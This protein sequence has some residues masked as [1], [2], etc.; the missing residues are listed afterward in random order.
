MESS[1]ID[2]TER[3]RRTGRP[4]EEQVASMYRALGFRA[5]RGMHLAG[6]QVDVYAERELAG[7]GGTLRVAI[8]VK[9]YPGKAVDVDEV[10]A[11][12]I[13][14]RLIIGAGESDRCRL[15]TTGTITKASYEAV[16]PIAGADIITMAELERELLVPIPTLSMWLANYRERAATSHFIDLQA[17]LQDFDADEEVEAMGRPHVSDLLAVALKN[18]QCGLVVLGD[19]GAGKS[20]SMERI[21]ALAIEA[22]LQDP[23]APVP[24]LLRLGK[25]SDPRAVAQFAL[26]GVADEF[27]NEPPNDLFWERLQAGRFLVL[28]DGFDEISLRVDAARR[29]DLLQQLS[30]LLFTDSPAIISTRP[31]YFADYAEYRAAFARLN[32]GGRPGKAGTPTMADQ[33]THRLTQYLVDAVGPANPTRARRASIIT[34]AVEP[35]DEAG[36]VEYLR[37]R[38]QELITAGTTAT[39][40]REFLG[41]IY[42][43]SELITRPIILKMAVETAIGGLI[44]PKDRTIPGGPAGLYEAYAMTRTQLDWDNV[45]SR[46]ELLTA[47]ERMAFAESAA[48]TMSTGQADRL[49]TSQ[50]EALA[51]QFIRFRPDVT[52]DEIAT[53]L[54]TCSFL[55]IDDEGVGLRFIHRSFREYFFARAAAASL[56]R[57][58]AKHLHDTLGW[59]YL[60]FLG[61][62]ASADDDL[63][64]ALYE[65][66]RRPISTAEFPPSR[67]TQSNAATALLAAQDAVSALDWRDV[68]V[69]RV[70]RTRLSISESTFADTS[71]RDVRVA[72]IE[73]SEVNALGGFQVAGADI[74]TV[75]VRGGQG[76][77]GLHDNV[78]RIEIVEGTWTIDDRS[79]ARQIDVN[80][81]GIRYTSATD[82]PV[83]IELRNAAGALSAVGALNIDA[84]E[85]VCVVRSAES[86]A[87]GT[88]TNSIVEAASVDVFNELACSFDGSI[89]I[90]RGDAG[91][92]TTGATGR[93]GHRLS[94]SHVDVNSDVTL[95]INPTVRP[96]LW[97]SWHMGLVVLGGRRPPADVTWHGITVEMPTRPPADEEEHVQCIEVAPS[98]FVVSG[99]GAPFAAALEAT[100]SMVRGCTAAGLRS[101][102]ALTR[103]VARLLSELGVEDERAAPLL[104]DLESR[105]ARARSCEAADPPRQ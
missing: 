78:G 52:I 49:S 39:E 44:N 89:L 2:E 74:E 79:T 58:S 10:R 59:E 66:A 6:K 18:P 82:D 64:Q 3:L 105:H 31:S 30:P 93:R 23:T 21:K 75:R 96:D 104:D 62:M 5:K 17:T 63:Y 45:D 102:T 42:D 71:L 13:S 4:A 50:V 68:D 16:D 37:Y 103:P 84:R 67:P 20:T 98:A 47:D 76:S 100:T 92:R 43:L 32:S 27:G 46:R 29:A 81:A 61:A 48:V 11:F 36:I 15:V 60:Y 69:P 8:E 12:A 72:E 40:L 22:L 9:D 1:E 94:R 54:R 41:S 95:I 70:R 38:D 77:L 57:R 101:K 14:A 19:F 65:L 53:D 97:W 90:V 26:R 7:I 33:R 83:N 25:L 99:A 85:S 80:S 56:K 91:A 51:S 28:L 73:L 86:G 88:I 87:E 55:T 35:L 34:Y 24:F